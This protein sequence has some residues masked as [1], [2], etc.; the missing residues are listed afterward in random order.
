MEISSVNKNLCLEEYLT[1]PHGLYLL[2][3]ICA[4]LRGERYNL[5]ASD[6]SSEKLLCEGPR[7][8]TENHSE[9][10]S[11]YKRLAQYHGFGERLW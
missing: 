8:D 7:A 3:Y 5:A 6:I 1:A 4:T 11:F 2:W 10:F 9:H